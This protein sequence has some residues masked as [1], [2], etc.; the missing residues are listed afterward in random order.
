MLLDRLRQSILADA[1]QLRAMVEAVLGHGV[2]AGVRGR[3][4]QGG[5]LQLELNR[6]ASG[7][8]APGGQ[9]AGAVVLGLDPGFAAFGWTAV[10]LLPDG[11][12]RVLELGCIRTERGKGNVL[13]RDD[14][15]RRAAELARALLTI[16]RRFEPAVLSAEALSHVNPREARM[17]IATTVKVGHAWGEVDMLTEQLETALVQ[18]APQTIKKVLCGTAS[19]SKSDVQRELVCR[20]PE[21]ASLLEPMP[22]SFREHPVDALGAVVATL[23]TNELRLARQYGRWRDGGG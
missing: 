22:A 13:V 20:Y 16:A 21:L 10:Q 14:D 4:E 5:P 15:R 19:A 9:F 23:Q 8:P 12:E 2:V 11:G 17:P 18:V 6:E 3:D 7:T 1:R